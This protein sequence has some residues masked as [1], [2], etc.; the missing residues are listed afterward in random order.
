MKGLKEN[1]LNMTTIGQELSVRA[2]PYGRLYSFLSCALELNKKK[3]LCLM[4]CKW[5]GLLMTEKCIGLSDRGGIIIKYRK[6]Y[7]MVLFAISDP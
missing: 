6:L 4:Y 2:P 3:L 7:T 5:I 1:L